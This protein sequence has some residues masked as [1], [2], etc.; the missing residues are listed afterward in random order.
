MQLATKRVPQEALEHE[1]TE[2]VGRRR[3]ERHGPGVGYRH[4]YED[5]TLKTAEDVLRVKGPQVR[6]MDEPYRSQTWAKLAKT[7]D[8]FKTLIVAMFVGGMSQR[9][10]AAALETALEQFVLS[11]LYK[12]YD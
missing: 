10:I 5:G 12:Y 1:Q 11:K 3:Y 4:G 6:G 2:V 7:S 8:H 9:D